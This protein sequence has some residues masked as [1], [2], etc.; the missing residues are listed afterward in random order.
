MDH[1][2]FK[3]SQSVEDGIPFCT[4]CGAPQIRVVLPD[5]VAAPVSIT[6]PSGQDLTVGQQAAILSDSERRFASPAASRWYDGAGMCALSALIAFIL[7][8]LQVPPFLV[9]FGVG[10]FSVAF[11]HLRRQGTIIN[12]KTGIRLGALGGLILVVII[13]VLAGFSS[14]I[15]ASNPEV[16]DQ[17]I[18]MLHEKAAASADPQQAE[19]VIEYIEA[20][21]AHESKLVAAGVLFLVTTVV[22]AGLGGGVTGVFLGRK[23]RR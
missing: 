22:I 19:E 1:P 4:H 6:T 12:G 5:A 10:V 21:A 3:C 17:M 9:M 13:A 7:I 15:V 2:C 18:K 20:P 11:Y 14:L 8:A 23:G 16:R